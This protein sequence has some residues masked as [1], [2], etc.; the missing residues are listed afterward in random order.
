MFLQNNQLIPIKIMRPT[1]TLVRAVRQS[2]SRSFLSFLK[3]SPTERA[4]GGIGLSPSFEYT[5]NAQ[6]LSLL[7]DNPSPSLINIH[8][9]PNE[10]N[11]RLKQSKLSSQRH[12]INSLLQRQVNQ[13][14]K[15]FWCAEGVAVGLSPDNNNNPVAVGSEIDLDEGEEEGDFDNL[16]VS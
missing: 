6:I 10:N 16:R 13:Q 1:L 3:P 14:F 15:A 8:A 2:Y 11:P 5:H 7:V 4:G 12:E 9:N